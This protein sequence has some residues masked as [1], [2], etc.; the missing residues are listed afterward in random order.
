MTKRHFG[1]DGLTSKQNKLHT[2]IEYLNRTVSVLGCA[3]TWLS[4]NKDF[5]PSFPTALTHTDIVVK[6]RCRV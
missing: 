1:W 2:Q 5:L 3:F 4:S 6:I